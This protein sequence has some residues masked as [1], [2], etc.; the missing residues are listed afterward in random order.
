MRTGLCAGLCRLSAAALGLAAAALPARAADISA[1]SAGY[2]LDVNLTVLDAVNLQAGP[3]PA[4][5]AGTA[6]GP[7]SLSG[8]TADV[9]VAAGTLMLGAGA[10][11]DLVNGTAFSGVDGSPGSKTTGASGGVTNAAV[12]AGSIAGDLL[13]LDATL[14]SH[15]QI[16]GDFGSLDATGGSV[17]ESLGL[18]ID[19]VP[20]DLGAY[21]GVNVAPNTTISTGLL[22]VTLVLN[23]Q[24][25]AP[26]D[27]S[28]QVNALNLS[29]NLPGVLTGDII[30]GHSDAEMTAAAAPLPNSA[31]S[32]S[33]LV[34]MMIAAQ[35]IRRRR[36]QA[37]ES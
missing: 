3:L 19:G 37:R 2:G 15:A 14:S 32:A 9:N 29:L 5:V 26:D 7:Y 34:A 18:A 31:A 24:I 33:L 21:V 13:T 20:I 11:A 6:P 36:M 1:S 16:T 10:T 8:S 30:L 17:I 35:W 12:G 27:S 23:Q 28:I 25:I 22:G 4:G